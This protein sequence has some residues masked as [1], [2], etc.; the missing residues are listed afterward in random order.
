MLPVTNDHRVQARVADNKCLMPG[1]PGTDNARQRGRCRALGGVARYDTGAPELLHPDSGTRIDS[2]DSGN[3]GDIHQLRDHF[4]KA[5]DRRLAAGGVVGHLVHIAV[6]DSENADHVGGLLDG[7]QC[8]DGRLCD[9][10]LRN[11]FSPLDESWRAGNFQAVLDR[12][13]EQVQRNSLDS[14]DVQGSPEGVSPGEGEVQGFPRRFRAVVQVER[15]PVIDPD[16]TEAR[17]DFGEKIFRGHDGN[18]VV[19]DDV[20]SRADH[21]GDPEGSPEVVQQRAQGLVLGDIA[22]LLAQPVGRA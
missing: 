18:P 13:K 1:T 19:G 4:R 15:G 11:L 9:E 22:V 21:D 8:V 17:V 20:D 7:R 12:K 2:R 5:H 6:L 16:Q 3:V 14:G 10:L